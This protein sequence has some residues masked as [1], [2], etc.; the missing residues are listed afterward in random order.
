MKHTFIIVFPIT[1]FIMFM[2]MF[3]LVSHI[4]IAPVTVKMNIYAY[5]SYDVKVHVS[6]MNCLIVMWDSGIEREIGV[7]CLLNSR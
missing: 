2:L 6:F 7:T 3:M 5:V 1:P 4:P